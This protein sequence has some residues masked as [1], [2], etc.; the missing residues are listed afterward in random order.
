MSELF[1]RHRE[2]LEKAIDACEKRYAWTAFTESPSSK[3]HGKDIPAAARVA[4]DALLGKPFVMDLP[5]TTGAVGE[6]VSPFT[7][8]ALGITYPQV[9]ID[10]LFAA[11]RTA[12]DAWC[13]QSTEERVGLC[14]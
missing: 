11:A 13:L 5:G 8:D 14:P 10:M 12:K 2:Q 7:E 9:D 6:E 3:V 1:E 4:F